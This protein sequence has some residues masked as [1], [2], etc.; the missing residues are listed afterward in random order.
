MPDFEFSM[1]ARSG[2]QSQ[3]VS[4]S[5]TSAQSTAIN[6]E[7]AVVTPDSACFFR[8]GANPTALSNGADQYLAA[9]SAYRINGLQEGDKLAF[10]VASGTG[11]VYITPGA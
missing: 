1:A 2:G 5:T 10:I 7:W 3:S 11:T 6:A 8:K 4:M 9:G